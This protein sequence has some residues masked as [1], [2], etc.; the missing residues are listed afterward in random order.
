MSFSQFISTFKEN[1]QTMVTQNDREFLEIL[2]KK[3]HNSGLI[4]P[5][6]FFLEMTKPLSLMGSHALVFLGPIINAFV[7]S[8]NYYRQVEVFEKPENI[9]LLLKMIEKLDKNE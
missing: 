6:V 5:A 3:I 4:T 8:E 7:Q 2:A 1:N 9:E